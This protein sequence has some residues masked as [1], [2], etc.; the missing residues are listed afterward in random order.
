MQKNI[1]FIILIIPMLVSACIQDRQ[2]SETRNLD[3]FHG[4]S[5]GGNIKVSLSRGSQKPAEIVV[6]RG[7]PSDLITEV[8]NGKL[9]IRFRG[10][11][12]F[13]LN[14]RQAEVNLTI[15]SLEFVTVSGAAS[16]R[17]KDIFTLNHLI[18][19]TSGAGEVNL[20]IDAEK[21]E[22]YS[23]GGSDIKLIGKSTHIIAEASGGSDIHAMDLLTRVGK[24]K[25]SGGADVKVR[26]TELLDANASGG[27]TIQYF[28]DPV[29][30]KIKK[31]GGADIRKN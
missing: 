4:I 10:G 2:F 19:R 22:C 3:Y 29:K 5:V 8:N 28:G 27:S 12:I 6:S 23:S 14:A 20:E 9:D 11:S 13:F 30:V 25:S 7:K 26:V 18:I 17:G 21:T 24:V 1:L 15:P 16:L 31:S